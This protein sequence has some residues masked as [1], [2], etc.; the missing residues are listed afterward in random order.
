MRSRDRNLANHKLRKGGEKESLKK[1][2]GEYVQIS[3][4]LPIKGKKG[5]QS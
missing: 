5:D 2:D 1:E 3:F 4:D